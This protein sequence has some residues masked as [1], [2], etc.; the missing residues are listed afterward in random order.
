MDILLSRIFGF[1]DMHDAELPNTATAFK[2]R[3]LHQDY[4]PRA[5][6][7]ILICTV[8]PFKDSKSIHFKGLI[9]K[10]K[11]KYERKHSHT[12]THTHMHAQTHTR[13]YASVC[14]NVAIWSQC[15]LLAI[16]KR[17]ILKFLCVYR[18]QTG[19]SHTKTSILTGTSI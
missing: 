3:K 16:I 7:V 14:R 6:D 11:A 17:L 18:H 2:A 8:N 19:C 1:K 10:I 12:H 9:K 15:L 5:Q 4:T 13:Y